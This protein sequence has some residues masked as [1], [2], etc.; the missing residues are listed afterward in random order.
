MLLIIMRESF[1][2]RV[3]K[4]EGYGCEDAW[5]K[6]LWEKQVE[7]NPVR[8]AFKIGAVTTVVCA[9][10]MAVK[11]WSEISRGFDATMNYLF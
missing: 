7:R 9:G 4:W 11:Y 6:A 8:D 3:K 10:V 5:D 1:D 2:E